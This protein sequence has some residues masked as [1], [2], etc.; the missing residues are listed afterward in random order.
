MVTAIPV[1]QQ[2]GITVFKSRWLCD[3]A[4]A[5]TVLSRYTVSTSCIP[6]PRQSVNPA[7]SFWRLSNLKALYLVAIEPV[8]E[9]L[10]N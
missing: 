8:A 3:E 5:S 9:H 2:A 1:T 10:D 6:L 7:L 4:Y